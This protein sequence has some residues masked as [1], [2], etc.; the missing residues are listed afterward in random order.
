M[1]SNEQSGKRVVWKG[2][3]FWFGSIIASY[4][5]VVGID[6]IIFNI[7]KSAWTT[8]TTE[9]SPLLSNE[10]GALTFDEKGQIWVG[11]K[12]GVYVISSDGLWSTYDEGNPNLSNNSISA[13]IIDKKG[14][15]W[16][17]A[18][19]GLYV[20][21]QNGSWRTYIGRECYGCWSSITDL[22]V[23]SQG[24]VWV[25]TLGGLFVYDLGEEKITTIKDDFGGTLTVYES[26]AT[27]TTYTKE[28]SG[29]TDTVIRALAIDKLNRVWIGTNEHGVN[30]LDQDGR[31][32]TYQTDHL[33]PSKNALVSNEIQALLIDQQDQLWVGTNR[34]ISILDADGNW[35]SYSYLQW[36]IVPGSEDNYT[37]ALSNSVRAF[38]SDKKGRVW[39]G[40]G[41]ELVLVDPKRNWFTYTSENSGLPGGVEALLV[42]ENEQLWVGTTKGLTVID[43]RNTLPRTIPFRPILLAPIRFVKHAAGLLLFPLFIPVFGPCYGILLLLLVPTVIWLR[44]GIKQKNVNLFVGSLL[45]FI[46]FLIAAAF[47]WFI[48]L[49]L[50]VGD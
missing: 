40:T 45:L 13:L 27:K 19:E 4:L 50:A 11:T 35:A 14:Q 9:N 46:F 44:R 5:I 7:F 17:G 30:V 2:G 23:D 37:Y 20:H 29:L 12:N 38:T 31:W 39:M 16:I 48:A 28:N 41:G 36:R 32:T 33:N 10:I 43:L 18:R 3:I 42:D 6:E 8:Y 47:L 1:M 24:R 22:S 49:R 15:I 34:G 21:E 26:N 25:A